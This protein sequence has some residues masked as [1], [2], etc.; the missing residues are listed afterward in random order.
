MDRTE[1]GD[2]CSSDKG[3]LLKFGILVMVL[4]PVWQKNKQG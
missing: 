4:N 2:R 3:T 1:L